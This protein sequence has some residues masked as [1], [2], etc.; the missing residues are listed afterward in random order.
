MSLCQQNVW[1]CTTEVQILPSNI[2]LIWLGQALTM[3]GL[4]IRSLTVLLEVLPS[5][6]LELNSETS[7]KP[8][9]VRWGNNSSILAWH[10][11]R[12]S[13]IMRCCTDKT[14]SL[15]HDVLVWEGIPSFEF[16]QTKASKPP[17][18]EADLIPTVMN[19]EICIFLLL[20]QQQAQVSH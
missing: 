16:H 6:L 12:I 8:K 10:A 13:T 1:Q 15:L 2:S 17:H 4:W 14:T 7:A 19:L 5:D 3:Y 11:F 20:N 18:P 9:L